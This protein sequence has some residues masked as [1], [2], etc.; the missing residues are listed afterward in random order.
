MHSITRSIAL[1]A[2]GALMLCGL[3]ACGDD[4]TTIIHE[5]PVIVQPAETQVIVP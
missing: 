3:A 4:E 1:S 5:K 2:L